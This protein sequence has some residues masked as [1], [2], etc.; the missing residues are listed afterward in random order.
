MVLI[1]LSLLWS[2]GKATLIP[3]IKLPDLAE[4]EKLGEK[5]TGN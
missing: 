3:G 4:L 1:M 2:K 5:R